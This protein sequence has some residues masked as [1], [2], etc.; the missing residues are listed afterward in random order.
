MRNAAAIMLCALGLMLAGCCSE[1]PSPKEARSAFEAL[2]AKKGISVLK[3]TVLDEQIKGWQEPALCEVK[4]VAD[5]Q[6]NQ[7]EPAGALA[8]FPKPAKKGEVA[9]FP[10]AKSGTPYG[11]MVFTKSCTGWACK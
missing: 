10:D 8:G 7:D 2:M 3:F 9:S 5:I 1:Y 4:Y 11:M 6:F